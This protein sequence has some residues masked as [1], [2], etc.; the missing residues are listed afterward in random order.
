VL[1]GRVEAHDVR[2]L[3]LAERQSSESLLELVADD[4]EIRTSPGPPGEQAL[5]G[6]ESVEVE[7][8]QADAIGLDQPRRTLLQRPPSS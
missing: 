1:C 7:R 5:R 4:R 2:D 8:A 3:G 6:R